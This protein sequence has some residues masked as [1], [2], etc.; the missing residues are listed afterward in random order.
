MLVLVPALTLCSTVRDDVDGDD[1]HG[2]DD[3]AA[4]G[5][6][7]GDGSCDRVKAILGLN[8]P[9]I[10]VCGGM[11]GADLVEAMAREVNTYM[12]VDAG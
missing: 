1:D 7:S 8:C 9:E 11:E 6:D 12:R 2:D 4:P 3:A 10:H 5:D